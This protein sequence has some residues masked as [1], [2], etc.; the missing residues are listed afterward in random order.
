MTLPFESKETCA[1]CG[2]ASE[3][4]QLLSTSVFGASDLDGRPPEMLRSTMEW[5]V[6]RCPRC[7]YCAPRIAEAS[8]EAGAV[9]RS[10]AYR[11]RLADPLM[12]DLARS[13]VCAATIAEADGG[14]GSRAVLDA[15]LRAAWSCD[16]SGDA[17]AAGRCRLHATFALEAVREAGG[18]YI[19][20]DSGGDD[21]LLADLYRRVGRFEKAAEAARAGLQRADSAFFRELLKLQLRLVAERDADA[22]TCEEVDADAGDPEAV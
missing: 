4:T 1:V 11:R 17:D 2:A 13:F 3:Q 16:D 20:D 6:Q 15:L 9:V 18:S 10:E 22:H 7:G 19:D 14:R 8:A 5:W 21:A 12:P